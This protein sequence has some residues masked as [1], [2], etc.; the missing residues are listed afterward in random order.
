MICIVNCEASW[1]QNDILVTKTLSSD[2]PLTFSTAL[3]LLVVAFGNVKLFHFLHPLEMLCNMCQD[4][5][6]FVHHELISLPP[7]QVSLSIP[8]LL[9]TQTSPLTIHHDSMTSSQSSPMPSEHL[10]CLAQ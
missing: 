9:P 6:P 3:I 7:T 4:P 8:P 10:L 1:T 5:S 2:L